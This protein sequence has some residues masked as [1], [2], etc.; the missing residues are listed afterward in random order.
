M[1]EI[2]HV[3][4]LFWRNWRRLASPFEKIYDWKN[5]IPLT[6]RGPTQQGVI[7]VFGLKTSKC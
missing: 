2:K 3:E 6:V 5:Q 1:Q 7:Y 4:N